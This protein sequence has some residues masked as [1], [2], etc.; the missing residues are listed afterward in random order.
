MKVNA[1]QLSQHLQRQRLPLYWIAGDEPYLID[2]ALQQLTPTSDDTTP[3]HKIRIHVD[4]GTFN[5][6]DL[7]NATQ[8]LSLFAEPQHIEILISGKIPDTLTQCLINILQH[9]PEMTTI[10]VRSPRLTPA[11]QK[12]KWFTTLDKMMGF[13][14]IWPIEPQQLT[15]WLQ[16]EARLRQLTLDQDACFYL[17]ESTE[18][19]LLAAAQALDKLAY[20]ADQSHIDL[21]TL[22]QQ[23]DDQ[24]RFDVYML[25]SCILQNN[26]AKAIKIL[27]HLK[28]ENTEPT[29]IVWALSKE[30]RLLAQ[31]HQATKTMPLHAAFKQYFIWP[32]RQPEIQ[33][34]LQRFAYRD[35]L[36]QLQHTAQL[37]KIIKGIAPGNPWFALETFISN[38]TLPRHCERTPVTVAIQAYQ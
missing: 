24:A 17:A 12:S 1:N 23:V 16:Q 36:T 8:S 29:L 7:Y 19:N 37:D 4:G 35:C 9:P 33:Q 11:Q 25:V 28:A 18:G 32:K 10:V 21:A 38:S 3:I 5:V 27:R 13:I 22:Q 14:P 30:F 6:D 34:A 26:L 20:T 15:T 2:Q 31:L